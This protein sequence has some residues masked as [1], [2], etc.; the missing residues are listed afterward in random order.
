VAAGIGA[1][2]VARGKNRW[3]RWLARAGLGLVLILT[4]TL[5][6]G[7]L[8]LRSSLPVYDGSLALPGLE[9]P[10]TVAR[11]RYAI[12]RVEAASLR[13][14]TFVQGFLHAQDRLFQMEFQ[15]RLASGRLSEVLGERTIGIDR[16]MRT[17]GFYRLAEASLAHFDEE[18]LAWL[19]AYAAGVNAFLRTRS[20]LLP[21]EFLILRHDEVEPWRPADSVVWI[22]MM[23]LNLSENWREEVLRTQLESR[24]SPDRIDALWQESGA[25]AP[26]TLGLNYTLRDDLARLLPLLP[27]P[28]YGS[29]AWVLAPEATG[30]G[31]ILANDPHLGLQAPGTWYLIRMTA[32]DGSLTGASLPGVPGIVL[33]HNGRIAWGLTTTGGDV[34]D[35]FIERVDPADPNRYLTPGGS[36]PFE[37]RVEDIGIGDEASEQVIV[38][39]TRHGPVISDLGGE[40]T[41]LLGPGEVAA[42]AW[43][44]LGEDDTTLQG[45]FEVM[46]ASDWEGFVEGLRDVVAPQQNVFYADVTGRVGMYVPGRVPVRR[47]GDGRVPVPGWTGAFDWTGWIPFEELPHAVDPAAGRLV[48]ANNKVVD[49]DY[50]YFLTAHWA[51]AYRARRIVELL[52]E[53][54]RGLDRSAAIQVDVRSM[55]AHDLL[56]LMLD[57]EPTDDAGVAALGLLRRWDLE[58]R[59]DAPEPLIFWAWFRAFSDRVYGDEL[60]PFADGFRR[61]RGRFVEHILRDDPSWCDDVRT[62]TVAEG[63]DEV[64]GEA[65]AIALDELGERFGEDTTAWRWG[66]AHRAAMAHPVFRSV[67]VLRDLFGLAPETPGDGATVNV[68]HPALSGPDRYA[69]RHAASFRGLYDLAALDRSRFVA[70]TGQSGHVLSPHYDDL[71]ALWVAG[72]GVELGPVGPDD[73][74]AR[75]L[76]LTPAAP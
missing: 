47:R 24:L 44:A 64:L 15:R 76:E 68:G 23:A 21:P 39:T 72:E 6:A 31:A 50:P 61:A 51:A 41:A 36:A 30:G 43:P 56:P 46:R 26:V 25:D 2:T 42:L 74:E 34:Q 32:A 53:D 16:F 8:A 48:N 49:D 5:L 52:D 58:T 11:E 73:A 70:A 71:S 45:L 14:A 75:R 37:V 69:N 59:I 63:C 27:E 54:A 20:G 3:R 62:T 60:G 10:A 67:P 18:T 57:I 55:L 33:G 28:G 17:L 40:E 38:R 9:A 1:E 19:E 35:L 65:L 12:P 13:D 29:N 7:W 22:K 4:L 66:E